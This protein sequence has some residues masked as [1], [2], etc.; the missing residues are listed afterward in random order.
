V[1]ELEQLQVAIQALESQRTTLGD[2]VVEAALG[3]LRARVDELKASS[4][5]TE[6]HKRRNLT[7]LFADVSGFTAMSETLDP[8]EVADIMDGLWR[9]LDQAVLDRGGL[10]DKHI[11]DAV[12]ALFG[13]DGTREDHPE[14]A[15]DA[16]LAM[17]AFLAQG[18]LGLRMRIGIHSG[19]VY[20]GAIGSNREFTA[21]GDTVNLAS[22]LEHA[23]PVGGILVSRETYRHVRGVYD[24]RP[25]EPLAVKGKVEPVQTY[26]VDAKRARAFRVRNRG[27]EGIET[28][29][30]GRDRE[31]ALLQEAFAGVM[32]TGQLRAVTLCGEAGVG[33]SRLLAEFTEW[34]DLRPEV[35]RIF[36]GRCGEQTRNHPFFL[37]KD[38]FAFRFGIAEGDAPDVARKKF[39]EGIGAFLGPG[40]DEVAHFLGHLV[41]HG[42]S[43]SPWLRGIL[44]DPGQIRAIAFHCLVRLFEAVGPAVVL[45][46]DLHWVDEGSLEAVLFLLDH[47]RHLPLL[48]VSAARPVF[49]DQNPAW[50]G[51]PGP[52]RIDLGTLSRSDCRTLVL[53]LLRRVDPVPRELAD[54]VADNAAGNPF[55]VEELVKMLLDDGIVV[56][57][58][59]RWTLQG[60]VEDLRIPST[61]KGVLQSRLEGLPED[62][63]VFLSR[64]AVVGRVFWDRAV[65]ALDVPWEPRTLD[66]VREKALIHDRETSSFPGAS[67]LVFHHALLHEV[68]YSLVLLRQ[69][70]AL[71]AEVAAWLIDRAGDRVDEFAGLIADHWERARNPTEAA[72]WF[73]RAADHARASFVPALALDLYRRALA[74][75]PDSF[76]LRVGLGETLFTL[77]RYT[78]AQ[79]V[80]AELVRSARA[81]G[82]RATEVRAWSGLARVHEAQGDYRAEVADAEAAQALCPGEATEATTVILRGNG[83]FALGDLAGA[84]AA[85]EAGL[86]L[87]T[88]HGLPGERAHG[89]N[90][91]G[92]VC[93]MGG[94]LGEA[95]EA[96]EEALALYRTQGNRNNES[97][98]LNNLGEVQKIRGDLEG[99]MERHRDNLTLSRQIG[100]RGMEVYLEVNVA[101]VLLGLGEAGTREA[102]LGL[103]A[104][105]AALGDEKIDIR[106]MAWSLLAIARGRLGDLDGAQDAARRGLEASRETESPEDQAVAWRAWG[107]VASL[108][109]GFRADVGTAADCFAEGVRIAREAGLDSPLADSLREWADFEAAS[110]SP[111]RARVLGEEA[112]SVYLRIG[113][114]RWAQR[115]GVR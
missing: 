115:T 69:R 54:L 111:D 37:L 5:E 96:F 68:T 52:V 58:D 75:D 33:K 30:V 90:L 49:W 74:G 70:R 41:G 4:R 64:A 35:L 110:G 40:S 39:A 85:A 114:D 18:T 29:M 20:L 100:N 26:V 22:R 79:A 60:R 80:W 11:G 7:V 27:I 93:T 97:V 66:G 17:Q 38:L 16:A 53:D 42:F 47:G 77:A 108:L 72:R 51:V 87:A 14:A 99:A 105:V 23:A 55:Y 98:V 73:G 65:T 109:P 57:G 19:L 28:R 92:M 50:A 45:L 46:E 76:S 91:L 95:Q 101:E 106:A 89:L 67:E 83:L 62:E 63:R 84:R 94:R 3:P 21:M 112:R 9:G 48:L 2:A 71:H 107:G 56:P 10:I 15:I 103:E 113:A 6:D 102:A 8:E 86:G 78:E 43:D 59:E 34:L 88:A 13:V 44:D 61:L 82:D 104:A 36:R 25:Q 81:A 24:V 12:M 31:L 1:S 32:G